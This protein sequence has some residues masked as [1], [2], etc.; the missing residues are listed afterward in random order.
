MWTAILDPFCIV[1]SFFVAYAM[2]SIMMYE[3]YVLGNSWDVR[4]PVD[5]VPQSDSPSLEAEEEEII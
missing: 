4:A 3:Y 2:G 5:V 1:Y